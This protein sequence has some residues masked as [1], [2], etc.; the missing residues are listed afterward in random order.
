M[1]TNSNRTKAEQSQK[2]DRLH[3]ELRQWQSSLFFMQ[4]EMI[5]IER[6][7]NSYI[8]EPNTPNLFE[9]I[10]DYLYRLKM[11]KQKRTKF[12]T[13]IGNHEKDLGG[14]LECTDDSCDLFYYQR[15]D[16]LKV[17]IASCMH[18]FQELKSEIFNYAGG[19]LKKRKPKKN[20]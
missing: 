17:E 3:L 11:A 6:L 16:T 14:M 5:F 2:V 15:H 4:D 20:Q 12:V 7:L 8:F 10:Q 13:L 9:R 19:I 1:N 18:S